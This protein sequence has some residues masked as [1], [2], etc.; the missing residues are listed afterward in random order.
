MKYKDIIG[1]HIPWLYIDAETLKE[2]AAWNGYKVEIVVE[3]E[4]YDYVARIKQKES[5]LV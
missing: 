4:H 2:Q 1:K 3:G 5:N